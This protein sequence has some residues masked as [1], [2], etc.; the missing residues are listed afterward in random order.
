M[1]GDPKEPLALV[2]VAEGQGF[3]RFR[4]IAAARSP[5]RASSAKASTDG[6]HWAVLPG[7]IDWGAVVTLTGRPEH[8]TEQLGGCEQTLVHGDLRLANSGAPDDEGSADRLGE[9]TGF[10][11]TPVEQAF[12]L[13]Q[14]RRPG[15]TG[16]PGGTG[17]RVRRA[18]PA[19]APST[20]A[21]TGGSRGS[22]GL[23]GG[24]AD[25]AG[26]H[27]E[28]YRASQQR[29]AL[30]ARSG[31]SLWAPGSIVS[32]LPGSSTSSDLLTASGISSHSAERRESAEPDA[33][34]TNRMR[35]RYMSLAGEDEGSHA[36]P[37]HDLCRT[38]CGLLTGSSAVL[39]E[40]WELG[41]HRTKCTN[42]VVLV[43]YWSALRAD[44]P[45]SKFTKRRPRGFTCFWPR[46]SSRACQQPQPR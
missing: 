8:L 12:F 3:I 21:D 35:Y 22:R 24:V 39:A 15:A 6:A 40:D 28:R 5:A 41:T 33:E 23:G 36:V 26:H 29:A 18:G 9:W 45:M 34:G 25:G 1:E 19:G 27:G 2:S 11:P 38:V 4:E 30:W 42:C 20:V 7:R 14:R 13:D 16:L 17:I 46:G 31:H 32:S 10:A 37:A 43:D 44:R